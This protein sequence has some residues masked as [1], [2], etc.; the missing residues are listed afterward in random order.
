MAEPVL[1][2]GRVPTGVHEV[3]CD[4]MAEHVRVPAVLRQLCGVRVPAEEL[5]DRGG[6]HRPAVAL[7]RGEE[8]RPRSTALEVLPQQPSRSRMDRVLP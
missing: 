6:G 3:Y 2:I 1:D 7:T 4:R 8:V 5:V